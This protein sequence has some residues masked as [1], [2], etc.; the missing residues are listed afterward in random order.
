MFFFIMELILS[1][2]LGLGL[3]AA[4]GF[5]VFVPLLVTS[6]AANAGHLQLASAFA[7]IGSPEALIAFSIATVLEVVA[8]YVPWLDHFLDALTT[9]AA[10]VAGTVVTASVVT[11]LSPLLK[12]TLAVIAGGGIAGTI[13]AGTVLARGLSFGTTGGLANPLVATAEFGSSVLTSIGAVLAPIVALALVGMVL[14]FGAY[15]VQGVRSRKKA[16]T[17]P[18]VIPAEFA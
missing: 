5:R 17:Q 9:P 15:R 12:W 18:P 16:G 7:W 14:G 3:A 13:Q 11:G 1:I 6:I 10:I 2:C 8:Y 4:C